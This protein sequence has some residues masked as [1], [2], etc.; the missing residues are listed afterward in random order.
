M[1]KL[2][3]IIVLIG[4]TGCIE[5]LDYKEEI[6]KNLEVNSIE[7]EMV[8]INGNRIVRFKYKKDGLECVLVSNSNGGIDCN[9]DSIK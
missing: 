4:L 3:L 6:L 8:L 2:L 5:A 7:G 9:W 1:K